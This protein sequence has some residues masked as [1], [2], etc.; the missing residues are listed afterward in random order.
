MKRGDLVTEGWTNII[1]WFDRIN[2]EGFYK[3]GCVGHPQLGEISKLTYPCAYFSDCQ[4]RIHCQNL[5]G[6]THAI[7]TNHYYR[8]Q[9]PQLVC[10]ENEMAVCRKDIVSFDNLEK[11]ERFRLSRR[12]RFRQGPVPRTKK[13]KNSCSHS[14]KKSV[15]AS[16][17]R[18]MS[19]CVDYSE[20]EVFRFSNSRQKKSYI[21]CG[22]ADWEINYTRQEKRCWKRT[23]HI[24]KA[25]EKHCHGC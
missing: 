14:G 23:K 25:W 13:Y 18:S 1:Y 20:D 4:D 21:A 8:G 7:I 2:V 5:T 12:Y 22:M 17:K 11:E 15:F 16:F 9:R 19:S 24:R 6:R 10:L 3:S